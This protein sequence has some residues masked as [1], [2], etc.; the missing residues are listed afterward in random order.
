MI[1]NPVT[2]V[3]CAVSVEMGVPIPALRGKGRTRRVSDARF[4]CYYLLT[5]SFGMSST[6]VGYAFNRDH[7]TVLHG[8][9]QVEQWLDNPRLNPYVCGSLLRLMRPTVK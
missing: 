6:E 7:A 9:R 2:S 8:L 3:L 4:V 1:E 5:Y